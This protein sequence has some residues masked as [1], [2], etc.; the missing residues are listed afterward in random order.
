MSFGK[1]EIGVTKIVVCY[2]G[3]LNAHLS[4]LNAHLSKQDS[5]VSHFL[6]L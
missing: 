6:G 3:S 4:S 2:F 5:S 1:G